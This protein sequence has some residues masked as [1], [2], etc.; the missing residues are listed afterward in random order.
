[1]NIILSLIVA[2]FQTVLASSKE[3]KGLLPLLSD[4]NVLV[5]TD[6]HSWVA[7]HRRHEPQMNADYGDVLSFHERLSTVCASQQKDLFFVMNGDFMHGTG[8]TTNPPKYLT[9]ILKKM[10]WDAINIGNHE[11]YA[12]S[13]IDFISKRGGFVDFW[14]GKYI[15]SNT[16][17][18]E[19]N[20][21]IG[22][23]YQFLEGT[24][25]STRILTFGFLYNME[26]S[27]RAA[28]VERVQDAVQSSW[29]T[30]VL[31]GADG[32]FG[33]ILVLAHMD[34]ADPL[35]SVILDRIR[36]VCGHR[37]PV[38]FI[39]GHSHMRKY[40]TLDSYSTSFEAGRYLDTLGFASFSLSSSPKNRQELLA[41]DEPTTF[42]NESRN[43]SHEE[44]GLPE[45]ANF[46]YMYID[47]NIDNFKQVLGGIQELETKSG[48]ELS[49][50][51]K[52]TQQNLGLFKIIGC[53]PNFYRA[54]EGLDEPDS[55]WGLFAKEVVPSQLLLLTSDGESDGYNNQ[56][57][58]DI[59]RVY[60]QGSGA[61][62]YDIYPGE[63]IVDDLMSVDRFGDVIYLVDTRIRGSDFIKAFGPPKTITDG[64][65]HEDCHHC[66]GG[67]TLPPYIVSGSVKEY[68]FYEVYTTHFDLHHVE[69]QLAHV[70]QRSLSP[71]PMK[72]N[73]STR[74]LWFGFVEAEWACAMSP[75]DG[76]SDILKDSG[77]VQL[78]TFAIEHFPSSVHL[79][80]CGLMVVLSVVLVILSLPKKSRSLKIM[81]EAEKQ[82]EE[83][84][85]CLCDDKL[86]ISYG[87][88]IEE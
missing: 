32:D 20:A 76:N 81:F 9:P 3:A 25:T 86:G 45:G 84:S 39:T 21:P 2:S 6:I 51:I 43:I 26:D 19:T 53:S 52:Q 27:C 88:P 87:L 65:D 69:G 82:K 18:S 83:T 36:E 10:P 47:T 15:T 37:M 31:K 57:N 71:V 34:A 62:Y 72:N 56:E 58:D 22:L 4:V 44:G 49:T 68:N 48:K 28:K 73:L 74:D 7:G 11:L 79:A 64:N 8:L 85:Y 17:H 30:D 12:N 66:I 78:P 29:F 60:I 41:L 55:L 63:I 50:F 46:Q 40:E 23:R 75:E 42:F 16:I 70:T 24:Y 54:S 5:V 80:L 1:M 35:V 13:T 14:D 77:W 59:H 33:A 67:G 61:Y 38:Q